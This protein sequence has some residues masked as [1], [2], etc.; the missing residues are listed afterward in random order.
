[1]NKITYRQ[2]LILNYIQENGFSGNKDIVEHLVFKVGKLDRTTVLR[3]IKKLLENDLIIKTGKGTH[4]RYGENIKNIAHRYFDSEIYFDTKA[5]KRQLLKKKFNFQVFDFFSTDLLLEKEIIKLDKLNNDYRKSIK[6]ISPTILKKEI[7]RLTIE[8]S[9]KSSQ[10][11]GNTYS[12]IDTEILIRQF[13]TAKNHTK[14]E[15]QMILNHKKAIDYIFEYKNNFEDITLAKIEDIHKMLISDMGVAHNIRKGVVGITGTQ[16]KPLDNKYQIKEAMEKTVSILNK[17][18]SHPLSKALS[19]ILLISYI[20]P[21]EDGNKRT[22]RL[23]SNAIL[24]AN[25]YCPLSFRSADDGDYKK[26]TLL[27]YEQ[28]S[29]RFF[30]QLFIEQFEFAVNTYFLS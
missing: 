20:Q 24:L 9:W 19:A 22:A 7:E 12:L 2:N 14:E 21:F 25:G 26:A 28:N 6:K 5:D 8:L 23:I 18:N 1:M 16:Y 29:I 17:K 15:A 3:D 27:F 11:E 10:I 30:K 4:I 13:K